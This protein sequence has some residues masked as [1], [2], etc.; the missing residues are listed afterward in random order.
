MMLDRS[1]QPAICTPLSLDVQ[2]PERSVMRNGIALNV[3]NA[4]D[5]EVVRLDVL[6]EG[7]RWHQS[8]PLQALFTNRMLREGTRRYAAADIAERLDYYGAWLELSSMAEYTSVTLYSLNKYFSQTLD[9]L[10]SIIKEPLF[11][12]K[13]LKVIIDA[14]VDRFIVN[15]SKVSFVAQRQLAQAL[16]G[17]S[18]PAGKLTC[19]DDYRQIVPEVLHDFYRRYYRSQN[20]SVY[21][22]GNVSDDTVQRVEEMLGK[23]R[24][25]CDA[26]KPERRT[27]AL[28]TDVRKRIFVE[29][30]GTMQ[31][32]V[33]MGML[34]VDRNHPD[35]LK[36]RVLITLLGGYFGSRLMSNIREQ[37]GYTYGISARLDTY[38][39]RGVLVISA[40][41]ANR[42]V[43]PLIAEV[44][45]EMDVLREEKVSE[46]ELNMVKNYMLGDMCRSCESAFSMADGWIFLQVSGL[47]D[48]YFAEAMK[49]VKDITSDEI[50]ELARKY[51]RGE[52]LK[53]IIVG[54]K[55]D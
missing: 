55:C 13:E 21:L 5:S 33:R 45:H 24:F 47:R 38:P 26:Q 36:L 44:Y 42:Y 22:S 14:N 30:K 39:D 1:I 41:T 25:G 18:H 11:P 28:E 19:E 20:C 52:D 43:E 32:A 10:E 4:C 15:S 46:A 7:G 17:P 8:Q 54:A 9:V 53:E 23:E 16:F 6:M 29:R 31:S 2:K 49:A 12:E 27:F 3:L 34:T 51:L 40:E 50:R 48:T 37:K 35:Y